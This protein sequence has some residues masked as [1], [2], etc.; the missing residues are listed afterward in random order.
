MKSRLSLRPMLTAALLA[1]L[2]GLFVVSTL[3]AQDS[4]EKIDI[5]DATRTFVVHLPKGYDPK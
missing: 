4:Q 2:A 1:C 5:D 3:R